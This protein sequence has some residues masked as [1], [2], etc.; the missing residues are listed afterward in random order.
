[1]A[2]KELSLK[3]QQALY[4]LDQIRDSLSVVD[5]GSSIEDKIAML[6]PVHTSLLV[7]TMAYKGYVTFVGVPQNGEWV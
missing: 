1:M 7:L 4:W 5:T 2:E 6:R 3:A